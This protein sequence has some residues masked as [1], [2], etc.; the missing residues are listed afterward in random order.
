[1]A[2][3]K[4]RI[5]LQ[6][7]FVDFVLNRL[8]S[9]LYYKN[10]LFPGFFFN[11]YIHSCFTGLVNSSTLSAEKSVSTA[12]P[13]AGFTMTHPWMN[14]THAATN[15]HLLILGKYG[16]SCSNREAQLML[17]LQKRCH[18]LEN[19]VKIWSN[20]VNKN[21]IVIMDGLINVKHSI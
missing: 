17:E 21:M 18:E 19:L 11:I 6:Q 12:N 15:Q 8:N 9:P 3:K 4:K 10:S 16:P 7:G 13:L 14:H 20:S 5:C 2:G 1:M